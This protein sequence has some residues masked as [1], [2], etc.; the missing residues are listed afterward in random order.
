MG[1]ADGVAITGL[2][3]PAA[4]A[5]VSRLGA[6]GL[7]ERHPAPDDRRKVIVALTPVGRRRVRRVERAFA[8]LFVAK[9][10][11]IVALVEVLDGRVVEPT[12]I[13]VERVLTVV[14][15]MAAVG[16]SAVAERERRLG[17]L[18]FHTG[19]ALA[20]LALDGPMRA[21]ELGGAV[22]LSSGGLTYLVDQLVAVDLVERHHDRVEDDRRAVLIDLTPAGRR[23][24]AVFC[25]VLEQHA[26]R[27]ADALA[28]AIGAQVEP[29]RMTPA[30]TRSASTVAAVRPA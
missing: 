30:T 8:A 5:L 22:G 7:V 19:L 2:S 24:L 18:P 10:D 29:S 12:P 16:T 20:S 13:P 23:V 1:P 25:G 26:T 3:R 6:H 9:A 17:A 27:F 11:E 21:G 4:A 28:A 15:G 14:A